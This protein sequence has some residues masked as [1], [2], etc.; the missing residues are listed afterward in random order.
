MNGVLFAKIKLFIRTPWTF[1]IMTAMTIL[2]TLILGT[3]NPATF[4]VPV[5]SLDNSLE[6]SLIYKAL[7]DNKFI[8]FQWTSMESTKQKVKKGKAELGVELSA[9]DFKILVGVNSPKVS[10][11]EHTLQEIYMDKLKQEK[12]LKGI[13]DKKTRIELKE[14]L[15]DIA[16]HAV[17]HIQTMEFKGEEDFIYNNLFQRVF[18]F[19][20]FFVIYTIA[21]NVF[22][23]LIEK[24]DGIWDRIILS[25]IK[26]WE[27]Y[28]G[29]LVY[30]F[31]AGYLQI[32]IVFLIFHFI[33]GI[34]FNAS[35][36]KLLLVM[37]PYVFAIVALT[38]LI[39]ALVK[40]VQQFNA[41]IPMLS[42]SMAMVGGAFWPIELVQSKP[43]LMIADLI[44]ITYGM[45][46]LNGIAIYN[47]SLEQLFSPLSILLLMG[48]G[49]TGIAIHFM[50]R[51]YI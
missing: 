51:R 12:M 39:T 48:V 42:V 20:L 23:I 38:I 21:Y 32:I 2:F 45:E 24:R 9:N 27:M 5:Y 16:A 25:P 37:I 49:M 44:P 4:Q 40:T 8:Q 3:S 46:L 7:Q 26:R 19:T 15:E 30:S 36:W 47:Y 13:K 41:I 1:V 31:V 11:V 18:G 17:F 6:D 50:E 34:E 14:Q 10:I 22:H 28:T 43:L 35:L 29:N 33:V